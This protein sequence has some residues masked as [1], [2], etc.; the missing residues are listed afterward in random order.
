[1]NN[2]TNSTN[3]TNFSI[4]G[5]FRTLAGGHLVATTD[6]ATVSV[7]ILDGT[8]KMRFT[9]GLVESVKGYDISGRECFAWIPT[10]PDGVGL[11]FCKNPNGSLR[12]NATQEVSS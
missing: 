7:P 6:R 12:M 3:S 11:F 1:M 9:A 2:S 4:S 10:L 5:T 8:I